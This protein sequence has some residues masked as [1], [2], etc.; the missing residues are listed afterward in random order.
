[1]TT[2]RLVKAGLVALLGSVAFGAHPKAQDVDVP[3]AH[4]LLISIDGLHPA[5]LDWYTAKYPNSTLA[6]LQQHGRT[7]TNATATKPSD[8]FPGT[9]AMV[10]GGTPHSTG[11]YYDDSWERSYMPN[12]SCVVGGT[13]GMEVIWKQGLDATPLSFPSW[14][15]YLNFWSINSGAINPSKLP[16]DPNNNCALVYPHAFPRVNNVFEV[17]KAAGGRTAWSD[18]HAAYEFLNGPSNTG[19]D[20]L[21]TPEIATTIG[22]VVITNSFDLTMRYDTLKVGA[23]VNEINGSD[24]FGQNAVGVPALFGMNFQAVSVGQK[25]KAELYPLA[26]DPTLVG[27]YIRDQQGNLVPRSGLEAALN[28]TNAGLKSMVDALNANG[29]AD[30]TL[31]VISAKHGNAPIDPATLFRVPV[32]NI[33]NLIAADPTL[34][35]GLVAQVSADTGPIVWLTKPAGQAR[36]VDIATAY[37]NSIGSGNPLRLTGV[38]SGPDLTAM[39]ADPTS[40]SRAPDIVLLPIPGTLYSTTSSKIAD[41]GSFNPDDVHVAL[42]VSNPALPQKTINDPVETRQ[43][44]C[45]I[46]HA[47]SMD[48]NTLQSEQIEPSRALPNSNHKNVGDAGNPTIPAHGRSGR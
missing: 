15:D 37:S 17:I 23:I 10:T 5:D 7:Y 2:T 41:H 44:A 30:S 28:N 48:C 45:T 1:M 20:D 36:A 31:I 21:Y 9:L 18:K 34:G 35:A 46:L 26:A 4:V 16:R 43:I 14:T 29:L 22:G 27:G 24:H 25:L 39:F 47:L 8:S 32:G 33:A 38:L 3:Y 6:A 13:G 12:A 42:L 19:L 11:V 40:D